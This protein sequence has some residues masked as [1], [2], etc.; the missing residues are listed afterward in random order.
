MGFW[1]TQRSNICVSAAFKNSM[2]AKEKKKTGVLLANL[3][4][5]DDPSPA[6][7][8]AFLREM[9]SDRRIVELPRVLWWPILHGIVLR[10]RPKRSAEAYQKI[11]TPEGSPQL[12]IGRR[13]VK[14]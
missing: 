1:I 9:L 12:A 8:R 5:P 2:S 4:T 7:V 10:V 13:L 6:G 11:W 3:G 14:R